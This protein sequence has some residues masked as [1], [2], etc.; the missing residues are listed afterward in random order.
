[1]ADLRWTMPIA[2]WTSISTGGTPGVEFIDPM[3]R[4]RLSRLS[5]LALQAAHDCAS[6]RRPLQMVFASRHG[7]LLRTTAILEDICAGEPVSPAAFS[8]SVLNAA[9]GVFGI[10]RG[11][12]SAATA[13][14]AGAET[15]GYG[16]LEAFAQCEACSSAVLFVYANEPAPV[17]YGDAAPDA[18]SEALAVL[19]DPY[20][21]IGYLTCNVEPHDGCAVSDFTQ[22]TA[23]QQCLADGTEATWQ[24]RD[25]RWRW[26]LHE[27][28]A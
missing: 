3:V 24:S 5:R 17:V 20:A 6:E 15:L 23:L 16:L 7:E 10:A 22:S 4:R 11:D 19:L 2:R 28:A 13:I 9:T 25:S 21:P 26:S 14:S 27:R 12:R 8:L 1:M 18:A